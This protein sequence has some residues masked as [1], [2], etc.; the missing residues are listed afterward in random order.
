MTPIQL[1]VTVRTTQGVTLHLHQN[2][3][4]LRMVVRAVRS[5]T[6]IPDSPARRMVVDVVVNET[7]TTYVR[8]LLR[9]AA[10]G[11]RSRF[12]GNK[13]EWKQRK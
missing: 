11:H 12:I 8:C 9:H 6:T 3:E 5:Y 7:V 10:R 1:P 2:R 13:R 4:L